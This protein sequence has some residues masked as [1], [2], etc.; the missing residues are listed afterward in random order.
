MSST[1]DVRSLAGKQQQGE[2]NLI[3]VRTPAEYSGLHAEGARNVPLDSISADAVGS[4]S[5][6]RPVYVICQAGN[7]S[8]KAVDKLVA[9]GVPH[10]VDVQGGTSAWESAGLPVVR[11]KKTVSLPRQVQ[12]VA[13]SMVL[14]G[15]ILGYF[16]HPGFIGLSGFVGAG[17]LFAGLTDTCAMA[18]I[19]GKM[20]WNQRSGGGSCSV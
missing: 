14:I 8:K 19:L 11:G 5:P 9:F 2:I 16:V 13:G 18:T 20:P 6:D 7:R 17:L 1:I 15:A 3:D 12:M 10:V 4:T